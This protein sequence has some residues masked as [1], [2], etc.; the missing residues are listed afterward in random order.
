MDGAERGSVEDVCGPAEGVGGAGD[1]GGPAGVVGGSATLASL[2]SSLSSN[3][4]EHIIFI[5][6]VFEN[7]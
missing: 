1:V 4:H 6:L 7:L 3:K 5:A 2:L